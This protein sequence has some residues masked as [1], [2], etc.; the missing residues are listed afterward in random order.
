M[1]TEEIKNHFAG[2]VGKTMSVLQ[3]KGVTIDRLIVVIELSS[4]RNGNKLITQLDQLEEVTI[5]SKAFRVLYNF[6]S[7]F[8]YKI[9]EVIITGFCESKSDFDEYVFRFKKYCHRRVCEVPDDSFYPKKISE[10]DQKKTLNIQIDQNFIDEIK[11]MKMEDLKDIVDNLEKILETNLCILEIKDGCIILTLHC[12]HELDAL[13][14][15]SCKQEK[16]LLEI[17]VVRIYSE[18]QEYY[19]QSSPF[20]TKNGT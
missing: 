12:L 3:A 11:R 19:Q 9:L 6:W 4:P 17:G 20:T 15:L 7:F 5:I 14:P 16:K 13:F 8:D 10:L 2:L 18:E 1:E